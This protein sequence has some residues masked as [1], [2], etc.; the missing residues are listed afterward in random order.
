MIIFNNFTENNDGISFTSLFDSKLIRIKIIDAYTGL[1]AWHDDMLV[2][3]SSYFFSYPRRTKHYGFEISDP[4]T[5]EIFL[6]LNIYNDGYTSFE[7]VDELKKIKDF[8]YSEK[9]ED[10][11]AAYP[12]YDIFLN[13]C[14]DDI[15]CH[16][17]EGD[18][19]FDIGA[20]LGL[21]SYYSILKGAKKVYAFEPGE[22]QSNAI[23]DNFGSFNNLVVEQKAVS[24]ETGILR[25]SKHKNKSILS[26]FFDDESNE[27]Y[28]ISE[29]YSVNLVDYCKENNI[30]KIN[31]LKIDCEGSEY[32]IFESLTDE[33][34]KNV[35]KVTM[36]YHLNINGRVRYLIERL[37]SNG[38]IVNVSNIE[39]EVGNLTAYNKKLNKILE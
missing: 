5:N 28:T 39:S 27:D 10:M 32:K 11:W 20:N 25:F 14:Y 21:F 18:I 19:V 31:F 3:R 38:F 6:K 7:D 4:E 1:I 12:L 35:D 29:C 15:N 24:S 22:S 13:K 16:V 23:K 9:N 33:F 36:E 30:N 17:N 2:G 8:K 34:I 26:G 37:E